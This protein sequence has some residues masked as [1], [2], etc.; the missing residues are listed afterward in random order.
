MKKIIVLKGGTSP[1]REVSLNSASAVVA[2]LHSL[3]HEVLELDPAEYPC[4]D[5][6]LLRIREASADLIFIA[7]HG[8]DGEN[9]R[10][11]AAF[12]LAGFEYTGSDSKASMLCMDKYISKLVVKGEGIP[13][14]DC[15][16]MRYDMLED[17]GDPADYQGIIDKLGM[18]LIVKPNDAGSSVGI[19]LVKDVKQLKPAITEAF[20]YCGTIL[21][22]Q[23]IPGRE[24]TVTV[25]SGKAQP[26]VEIKPLDGW[27]D[28]RNKYT[29]GKT[30]YI[31]PAELEPQESELLQL[32]AE[33]IWK[34]TGIGNYA[35]IDFRYDG[36]KA[37]FL[38]VNTLPGMTSLSLT[39]MAARAAGMS[40]GELI[41]KIIES[42]EA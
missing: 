34:A 14:P 42:T 39:P 1:E 4:L 28:Y 41:T 18:P 20:N 32:Y 10:L 22:E 38:E 12:E 9:G 17:Y 30:E 15:V 8:G 11:Q 6:L 23:Y 7:L 24:L 40:F 19:S 31:A 35:R 33:K 27:Y 2:E 5:E 26:V 36:D 25:I 21:L 29:K 13:V 3:G 37:Y 16:L